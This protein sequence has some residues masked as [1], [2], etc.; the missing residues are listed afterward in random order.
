MTGKLVLFGAIL[1]LVL[2]ASIP[3]VTCPESCSCQ[4]K[5]EQLEAQCVSFE[6]IKGLL[7]KQVSAIVRLN[8]NN[9]SLINIDPK[10]KYLKNLEILDLSHNQIEVLPAYFPYLPKLRTLILS[11]NQLHHIV[12]QNLPKKLEILDVS[13]NKIWNFPQDWVSAKHLKTFYFHGNPIDCD[14]SNLIIYEQLLLG[15]VILPEIPRCHVP[16]EFFERPLNTVN[17]SIITDNL[18]NSM[19]GDEG[20]GEPDLETHYEENVPVIN[21]D[22]DEFLEAKTEVNAAVGMSANENEDDDEGSGLIPINPISEHSEIPKACHVNCSTPKPIGSNDEKNASPPPSLKE[23]VGIVLE[24]IFNTDQKPS[25]PVTP[26]EGK[27]EP[28]IL[29]ESDKSLV[30][31]FPTND[32][33]IGE[34]ERASIQSSNPQ[35]VYIVVGLLVAFGVFM[36]IYYVNKQRNKKKRGQNPSKRNKPNEN[37]FGEEMKPMGK[38]AEKPPIVVPPLAKVNSKT[39]VAEEVPLLNGHNGKIDNNGLK[40]PGDDDYDDDNVELRKPHKQELLTPQLE[41]VTIKAGEIPDS[42]PR[43]PLLV[44]RQVNNDGEIITT[45]IPNN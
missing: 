15:G 37:G 42:V 14:C 38:S 32:T 6:F 7:P 43:T 4:V 19:L 24:D 31:T 41:R 17:C 39:S 21:E 12:L 27:E 8:I 3:D 25:S 40:P 34:M 23:Q 26:Q 33:I 10:L 29:K 36:A 5:N 16:K 18:L 45:A 9:V 35:T 44:H 28:I 20:S 2:G 1:Q 11:N 30:E 22:Q 13:N